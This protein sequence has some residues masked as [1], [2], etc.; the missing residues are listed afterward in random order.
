M[1]RPLIFKALIQ[2]AK[3]VDLLPVTPAKAADILLDR[4]IDR[5]T[6]RA[7]TDPTW[8]MIEERRQSSNG[9]KIM[10]SEN[11]TIED[12]ETQRSIEDEL[13]PEPWWMPAIRRIRE[14]TATR[15]VMSGLYF[16]QRATRGWDDTSTWSLDHHLCKTLADQL[17]HLAET[18]HT[19]PGNDD[20]PTFETWT[21]ELRFQASQL[22][23]MNEAPTVSLA[24]ADLRALRSAGATEEQLKDAYELIAQAEARDIEASK[25]ALRW[26]ADHLPSLWD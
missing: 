26:V 21:R 13:T 18:T 25:N 5:K 22:R 6:A 3:V 24:E 11:L 10:I 16:Y 17:D 9:D 19:Y 23:R 7:A 15:T 12:W 4:H 2:V 8:S 1:S 14:I 20:F